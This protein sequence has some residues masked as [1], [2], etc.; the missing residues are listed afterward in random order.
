MGCN[1]PVMEWNVIYSDN[2]IADLD[3]LGEDFAKKVIEKMDEIKLDP[4]KQLDKMKGIPLYKFRIGNHR[5]IVQ[6]INEKL[7]LHVVKI[8][9][10][11]Q[12]YKKK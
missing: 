4:Y 6:I 11:S 9:H 7:I 5:G 1:N 12:V 10:R 8:K 2:V 3:K